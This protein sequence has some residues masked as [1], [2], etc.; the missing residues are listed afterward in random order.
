MFFVLS[1]NENLGGKVLNFHE[2]EQI[3]LVLKRQTMYS[4]STVYWETKVQV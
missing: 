1:V 4:L 3:I 2:N